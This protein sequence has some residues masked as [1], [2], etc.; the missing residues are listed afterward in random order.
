MALDA[1]N[2]NLL[3]TFSRAQGSRAALAALKTD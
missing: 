3:I 2:F 1:L